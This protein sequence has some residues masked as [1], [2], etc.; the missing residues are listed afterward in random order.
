MLFSG[1]WM[2]SPPPPP[3]APRAL[4]YTLAYQMQ[5]AERLVD[6]VLGRGFEVR[7]PFVFTTILK[8]VRCLPYALYFPLVRWTTR[9][10]ST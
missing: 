7:F 2:V 3:P 5:A 6:G 8:M 4:T 1:C 9:S 10:R